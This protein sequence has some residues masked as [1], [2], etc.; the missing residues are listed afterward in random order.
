M[1]CE[2]FDVLYK[3]TAF[4]QHF[5]KLIKIFWLVMS[6]VIIFDDTIYTFC[7]W[8]IKSLLPMLL[9]IIILG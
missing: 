5:I 8:I 2:V 7:M 4:I 9:R 1:I 6:E 3:C